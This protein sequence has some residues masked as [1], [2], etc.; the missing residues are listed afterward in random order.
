MG[1]VADLADRVAVMYAGQIVEQG[2]RREVFYDAQHPYTWGLLGSIAR[3]DRPKPKRLAAIPVQPPSLLRLS[4]GCA[5][6]D[7]CAH[8][9][10]LCD[11]QPPLLARVGRPPPGRLPPGAQAEE[12]AAGDHH[13]PRA[14]RDGGMTAAE[15]P[16]AH[17][18]VTPTPTQN[19]SG[20]LLLRA[21]HVTKYFPIRS[22]VLLQREVGRVHAVDDVSIEL[23]AGETLG[24]VGESGLRQVHAGPVHRPAVPAHQRVG[25]VRGPGHLPAVPAQ[26]AA[27]AARAADGVPGPVRLAQPAQAGR[28]DHLPT[29]CASTGAET[30]T[31]SSAGSRELLELVGLVAG[32]RQPLPAR[33]LRRAAAAHRGSAGPGPAPQ[34]DHRRRAGLRP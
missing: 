19:G 15:S 28:R 20:E 21:E 29:R 27:G 14:D 1:V 5:F 3:L 16:L 8:R 30:A 10:V 2:T 18:D 17:A 9:F 31:R 4:P 13:P 23:R 24:L 6:A 7:R 12:G 26:A 11:D 34:A 33:V 32:A 22:G 25:G